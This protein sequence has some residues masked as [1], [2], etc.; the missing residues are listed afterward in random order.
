VDFRILACLREV[1]GDLR[2]TAA[3]VQQWQEL[4]LE[5]K[6][7]YRVLEVLNRARV[8]RATHLLEEL[9]ADINSGAI[10]PDSEEFGAFTRAVERLLERLTRRTVALKDA[11]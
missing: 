5:G 11:Q 4:Q 7:A 1:V 8:D 3:A 9:T 6:D 10:V 2:Q